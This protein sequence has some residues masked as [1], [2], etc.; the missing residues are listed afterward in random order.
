MAF[1]RDDNIAGRFTASGMTNSMTGDSASALPTINISSYANGFALDDGTTAHF[2]YNTGLNPNGFTERFY[3][4]GGV[5][6]RCTIYPNQ[7][8]FDGM[9]DGS[10][11]LLGGHV[12]GNP[13][14]IVSGAFGASGT[15][16][17][18]VETDHFGTVSLDAMESASPVFCDFGSGEIAPDGKCYVFLDPRF[19]ETVDLDCEYQVFLTQIGDGVLGSADKQRDS[20]SV[21]GDPGTRFDWIVYARQRGYQLNRLESVYL[22][23]SEV[24]S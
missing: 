1:Y 14:V 24:E 10:A 13:A 3:V 22:E 20:F 9:T 11:S 17:R 5:R 7:I 12:G 8:T 4:S 19:A 18:I 16:S 21:R 15:K 6:A 23:E 2:V